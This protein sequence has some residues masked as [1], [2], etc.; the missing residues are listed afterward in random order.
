MLGV[1]CGSLCIAEEA[2]RKRY[3]DYQALLERLVY[4]GQFACIKQLI[5]DKL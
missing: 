4:T 5:E 1:I 2:F 3:A